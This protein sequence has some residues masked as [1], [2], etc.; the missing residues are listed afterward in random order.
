LKEEGNIKRQD[1]KE[2]STEEERVWEK[3]VC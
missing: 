3:W 1:R 2:S